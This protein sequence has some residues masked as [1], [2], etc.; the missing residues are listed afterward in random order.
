MACHL[1]EAIRGVHEGGYLHCALSPRAFY[2]RGQGADHPGMLWRLSG[3]GSAQLQS[4]R[5]CIPRA[6]GAGPGA[7]TA[8]NLHNPLALPEERDDLISWLFIVAEMLTGRLPWKGSGDEP[9]CSEQAML[10][11][12]MEAEADPKELFPSVGG[13]VMPRVGGA[14]GASCWIGVAVG[15]VGLVVLC[16]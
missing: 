13:M 3:L 16:L 11:L 2:R 12:K 14:A 7:H 9:G 10:K 6:D 15:A 4:K 1:L 5:Q 8:P